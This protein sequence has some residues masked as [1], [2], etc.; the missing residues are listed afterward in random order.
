MAK[1]L[2]I[3]DDLSSII[4]VNQTA[5]RHDHLPSLSVVVSMV[6]KKFLA[7]VMCVHLQLAF[8][9]ECGHHA[10]GGRFRLFLHYI[11]DHLS[12]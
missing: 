9:F 11:A 4:W 12:L 10:C 2:L 8:S 6:V 1:S 7:F 5:S 3:I